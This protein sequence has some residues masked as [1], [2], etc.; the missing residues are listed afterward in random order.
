MNTDLRLST[1]MKREDFQGMFTRQ[2]L[3]AAASVD[4]ISFAG[5]LPN[6]VSFPVEQIREAACHVLDTQGEQALQYGPAAGYEPLRAYIAK[7]YEKQGLQNLTADDI[8][9]TNGSQQALDI[10]GAVFLDEG[11]PI[12]VENPSYLAALQAFHY[13]G[14]AIHTVDL[15]QDGIDCAM[16]QQL[17]EKERPKFFYG[18]PNFQ[19]PTGITYTESVRQKMAALL[20]QSG[21]FFIEDNPYGELRFEG[22]APRSVKA[23]LGDYCILSGTFSKTVSPGMRIGWLVC[24]NETLR[25]KMLDYKQASDIH[26]NLFSQMILHRYLTQN[27]L[28]EHIR[29]ITGLY[30]HQADHM[31]NCIQRYFPPQVSC[32]RPEGG[33]FLWA[34]LPEGLHAVELAGL[35]AEKGV[36]IAAGD[37][38]YENERK[39]RTFRLNYTNCDDNDIQKGISI[40]GELIDGLLP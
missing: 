38:F 24:T 9:I 6:P 2:I 18:V 36:A 25:H 30:R 31:L 14:P 19:N 15:L 3:K 11:D 37:P 23:F 12:L 1:R 4:I 22:E 10:L 17:L 20:A 13:Y 40:L 21:T 39:V 32:P 16:L 29:R 28:D 33:M 7:R 34:E 26:T 5:G 8:L 35:A 27:S